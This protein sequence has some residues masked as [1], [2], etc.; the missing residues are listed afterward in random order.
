MLLIKKVI[1]LVTAPGTI[2]LLLLLYGAWRLL[3]AR[4]ATKKGWLSLGVGVACF[5][6]FTT[7]P[8]PNY[9]LGLLEGRH[10][11]VPAPEKLSD[12]DYIVVLSSGVRLNDTVPPTSQLDEAS[13]FRVLEGVRLFHLLS[14][15]PTLIMTG[16]GFFKDTGTRMAALAET[17]GVPVENLIAENQARDTHGNALAVQGVVKNRPFLLVTSAVHM[18]RALT[19]FQK[20]GLKPLAAPADFRFAS[21][22][23]VDDFFPSGRNLTNLETAVHEY[24]G[25][26]YLSLFPTR[27][28]K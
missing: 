9:L 23:S 7:A 6:L 12:I 11:A 25:L 15:S 4:G 1:A 13:A 19:I 5:I 14:G 17:L 28:G 8:L 26:A 22:Y 10:P 2:I 27:A 24:L 20:L 21:Y 18:P 3:V 16:C